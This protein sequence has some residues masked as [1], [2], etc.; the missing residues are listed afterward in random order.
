MTSEYTV[1]DMFAG[2]GGLTEGFF[3]T[4]Y[5][6]I[7]HIEMDFHAVMTLQTR[8][9]FHAL[10]KRNEKEIYYQYHSGEITREEFLNICKIIG[11][12]E[13]GIIYKEI[14]SKTEDAIIQEI[15]NKLRIQ[16]KN[17][18]DVIIGGPPCQAY[19]LIGRGRDPQ[20]MRDDPRNLL[21]LHYL[22]FISEFEP[23][24]FVFENVLGL[25]SARKGKI[26]SDFI[27]KIKNLG[28]YIEQEPRILN[29]RDFGA[30]QDRK[31]IFFIGW[32]KNRK[33]EY[34]I[35]T[36]SEQS[37]KAWVLFRDLHELEPGEGTDGPQR[38][39]RVKPS[40][41]LREYQ[42]RTDE[43]YVR[44]HIARP[45]NERDRQIYRMA[46]QKWNECK[47][48]LRYYELPDV[49]K[50]HRNQ[51]AFVDRFKVV[52]GDGLSHAVLAHLSQDGHHFI[53]PDI[54]QARSI[55]VREAARIQSFPDNYL[56]EGPRTQQFK[57]IG[58]AVPPLMARGIARKVK[59]MLNQL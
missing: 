56:F 17:K 51:Y 24:I 12:F 13:T 18:I 44:H 33:L 58:N 19:S 32:K 28:Y 21:Y 40:K 50:T 45:H 47:R 55:T 35:F 2:A 9:L 52:D 43:K 23:E 41:Y 29:S 37:Y 22:K 3:Q 27:N 59:E 11:I 54:K 4:G 34:P 20:G 26:Y 49:L 5:N 25:K 46:I 36:R 6:M 8:I 42:I 14:S 57:Q 30:L 16:G 53:H 1:L 39:R 38:Y 31:R 15:H 7:S 48:R 10:C